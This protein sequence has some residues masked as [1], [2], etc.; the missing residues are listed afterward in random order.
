MRL[1]NIHFI[2][3]KRKAASILGSAKV[4]DYIEEQYWP[5]FA[6]L[7]MCNLGGVGERDYKLNL[8]CF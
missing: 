2:L 8:E 5:D 3:V 7:T 4:S 1:T 6:L